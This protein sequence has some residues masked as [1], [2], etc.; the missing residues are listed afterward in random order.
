MKEDNRKKLIDTLPKKSIG[1][2]I[3]VHKG[4]FSADLLN[5]LDPQEL[6]LIDPWHYQDSDTYK[7]SWYGGLSKGQ[8]EMDERYSSVNE[9]FKKEIEKLTVTIHRKTSTEALSGFPDNYFDWIYIDGNHLF[10]YV[11]CD[12]KLAYSKVKEKG[13]IC[14][15]DY[16]E[17]G[18][19]EGGVLRAVDDF[20]LKINLDKKIFGNQFIVQK[21]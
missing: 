17:G 5:A 18:W 16:E 15:D 4:D 1:A 6:H 3:G 21:I 14:G 20:C 2:E 9:K 8:I 19:W 11:M 10:D 13:F 7:N 12:L